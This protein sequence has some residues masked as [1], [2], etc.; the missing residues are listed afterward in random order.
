MMPTAVLFVPT[1]NQNTYWCKGNPE[2]IQNISAR[3]IG[4]YVNKKRQ[5]Y[6]LK[7]YK[8]EI[9]NQ[10]ENPTQKVRIQLL[11]IWNGFKLLLFNYFFY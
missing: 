10:W 6:L 5:Q 9:G 3:G 8:K 7:K 1:E 11:K 2:L 4:A